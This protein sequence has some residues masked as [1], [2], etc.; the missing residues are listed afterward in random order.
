MVLVLPDAIP[1]PVE[2][3]SMALL[4]PPPMKADSLAVMLLEFP[5]TMP[6]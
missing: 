6:E 1:E 5:E 4:E 3:D 2:V